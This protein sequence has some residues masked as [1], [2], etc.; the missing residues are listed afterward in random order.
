MW[1]YLFFFWFSFHVFIHLPLAL[2][3]CTDIYAFKRHKTGIKKRRRQSVRHEL[4]SNTYLSHFARGEHVGSLTNFLV[5]SHVFCIIDN[6]NSDIPAVIS[7]LCKSSSAITLAKISNLLPVLTR[8]SRKLTFNNTHSF[9]K[10][11]IVIKNTCTLLSHTDTT[12][13]KKQKTDIQILTPHT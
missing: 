8:K 5:I 13:K 4:K 6:R 1:W 2:S 7:H 3:Q 9:S 10:I 11:Q 12:R